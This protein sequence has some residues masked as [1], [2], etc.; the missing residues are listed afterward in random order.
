MAASSAAG[1]TCMERWVVVASPAVFVPCPG[2]T[3]DD[4]EGASSDL[5]WK[6]GRFF[7]HGPDSAGAGRDSEPMWYLMC[8]HERR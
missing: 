8:Y 4:N 6:R 2:R 5:T 1:L 3:T 7:G